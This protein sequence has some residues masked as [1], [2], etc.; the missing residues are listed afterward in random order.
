[1]IVSSC[2][3]AAESSVVFAFVEG[4]LVKA[5]REGGWLLLDEVN[6]APPETL[7][8]LSGLLDGPGGSLTLTE[9]GDITTVCTSSSSQDPICS[10]RR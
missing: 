9:R 2:S 6:L 5:L 7:E 8:R 4:A 1:M 3:Q 10:W